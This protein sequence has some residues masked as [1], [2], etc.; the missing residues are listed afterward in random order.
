MNLVKEERGD[1]RIEV[2]NQYKSFYR[3]YPDGNFVSLKSL[4]DMGR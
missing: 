4:T 1:D 3:F 2:N